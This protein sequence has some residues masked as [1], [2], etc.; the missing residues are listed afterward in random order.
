MDT[1]NDSISVVVS[2]MIR[3]LRAEQGLTVTQLAKNAGVPRW[4][5]YRKRKGVQAWGFN[6][7]AA[8]VAA[9]GVDLIEFIR[10]AEAIQAG[11][12]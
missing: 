12:A 9:L 5:F 8:V 4:A 3:D 7:L 2:R 10:S 1:S 11:R 6:E